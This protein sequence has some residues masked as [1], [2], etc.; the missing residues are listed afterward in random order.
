MTAS[1]EKV[2]VRAESFQEAMRDE[3]P[4]DEEGEEEEESDSARSKA[5]GLEADGMA[6]KV[7]V[8]AETFKEALRD[9]DLAGEGQQSPDEVSWSFPDQGCQPCLHVQCHILRI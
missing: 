5:L 3:G 1:S 4:A 2:G 7:G 9:E 6:E 8:R